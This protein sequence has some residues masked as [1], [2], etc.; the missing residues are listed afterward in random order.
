VKSFIGVDEH[1]Y[2]FAFWFFLYVFIYIDFT[3]SMY[4]RVHNVWRSNICFM[5]L[6]QHLNSLAVA[7]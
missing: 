5:V 7:C 1:V 3:T 2:V 4:N 6:P